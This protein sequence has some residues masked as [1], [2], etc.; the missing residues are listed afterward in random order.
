MSLWGLLSMNLCRALSH[1]GWVRSADDEDQ[2][3]LFHGISQCLAT[4]C[5]RP[6][7]APGE[8]AA[9]A[10]VTSMED[11][12]QRGLPGPGGRGTAVITAP[13]YHA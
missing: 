5:P 10:C 2:T 13:S 4:C 3:S 6:S 8:P 11:A 7:T 9:Q 1:K 12:G